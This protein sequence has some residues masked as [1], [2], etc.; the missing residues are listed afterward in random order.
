[1]IAGCPSVLCSLWSVADQSTAE[2]MKQF[3][4][5]LPRMGKAEALRIAQMEVKRKY[6]NPSAWA[7]FVLIGL[8]D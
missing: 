7:A 8:P 3:Y 4:A 5:Q 1:M 6:P 2:V